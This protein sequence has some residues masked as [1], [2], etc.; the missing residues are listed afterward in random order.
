VL[1]TLQETDPNLEAFDFRGHDL[2]RTAAT[3]MAEAGISQ[4]DIAKVLNH[5][6]GGPRATQVYN[7]YAYDREKQIAMETWGRVL[8]G[9]LEDKDSRKV[10]AITAAR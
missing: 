3:K 10:V 4:S 1:A 6:E 9:I 2:R 8:T 5:A 7:R